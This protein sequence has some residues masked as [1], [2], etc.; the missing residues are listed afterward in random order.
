MIRNCFKSDI[1]YYF[2]LYCSELKEAGFIK[3]FSYETSTFQLCEPYKRDYLFQGKKKI[4]K[5]SEHFLQKSSIT[6]DF[7]IEWDDSAENIFYLRHTKPITCLVK[8]IPFRLFNEHVQMSLIETKGMV[9]SRTSSSISFPLKQKQLL[10][11]QDI[12]IQKIKPYSSY[13]KGCLFEMTFT[14][15]KVLKEERYSRNGS[16]KR[17]GKKSFQYKKGESKIKYADR[18][19]N[20]FLK[21]R[22]YSEM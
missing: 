20:E 13:G 4:V 14:P 8:N 16:Y 18:D 5:K 12:Y 7:T 3:K 6:A 19:L 2:Y 17:K 21:L 15:K 11:D 9:E 1:E 10:K 22:N